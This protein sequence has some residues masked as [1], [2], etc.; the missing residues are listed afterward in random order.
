MGIPVDFV[1]AGESLKEYN[2]VIAPMLVMATEE[3]QKNLKEYAKNGGNLVLTFR[4]GIK[5]MYNNMLQETVPGYFAELA[6]VEVED[7]DPLLGKEYRSIWC[8]WKKKERHL[9]GVI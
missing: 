3:E 1:E 7:Y 8:V 6:G 9:C 4:S 5:D 2:L